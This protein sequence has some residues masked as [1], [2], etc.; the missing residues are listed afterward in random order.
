MR[1]PLAGVVLAA[2]SAFALSC[3]SDSPS[4]APP[5]PSNVTTEAAHSVCLT[6]GPDGGTLKTTASDGTQYTLDIPEGAVAT[7][8]EITL[9]PIT[10]IKGLPVLSD[11]VV[12]GV[13]LKPSGLRWCSRPRAQPVPVVTPSSKSALISRARTC[14]AD[15]ESARAGSTR[16]GCAYPN[17]HSPF[18]VCA[19]ASW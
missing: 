3:G 9:T 10:A 7:A 6:V 12:A 13:D 2:L 14:S 4:S 16:T 18:V 15:T 1:Q 17:P 19:P 5:T 8:Q 11:R